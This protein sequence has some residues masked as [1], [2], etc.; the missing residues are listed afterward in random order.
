VRGAVLRA[1][2]LD[3]VVP[4]TVD[5][6]VYDGVVTLTG[7]TESQYRRDEAELVAGNVPGVIALVNEISLTRPQPYAGDVEE[8]IR[9][10]FERNALLDARSVRVEA[11]DGHIRL[12]GLV[13]SWSEHDAALA[14]TWT[15]P[16]VVSVEDEPSSTTPAT[17]LP[18]A[19]K[20]A[21]DVG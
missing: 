7:R 12:S 18:E 16:G 19:M 2:A 10:A 17:L 4:S 15:A 8:S 3:A 21:E 14:A 11:E 5:A 13:P 6:R 20:P 1:L 9:N